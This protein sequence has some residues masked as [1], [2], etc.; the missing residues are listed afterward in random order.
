MTSVTLPGDRA[1]VPYESP[2][3]EIIFFA[4]TFS[5]E[6]YDITRRHWYTAASMLLGRSN[7]S[8]VSMD[9]IIYVM[10]GYDGKRYF[11]KKSVRYLP[12]H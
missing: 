12:T 5:V 11:S 9:G 3:L 4:F 6:F 2:V 7:F 10:G 1:K 8:C